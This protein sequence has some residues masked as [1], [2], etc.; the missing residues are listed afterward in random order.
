[1][2]ATRMQR[3]GGPLPGVFNE[4]TLFTADGDAPSDALTDLALELVTTARRVPVDGIGG[5]VDAAF[6]RWPGEH[7]RLLTAAAEVVRPA[8]A[9]D[10]GTADGLSSLALLRSPGTGRVVTFDVEPWDASTWSGWDTV[11]RPSDFGERLVQVVADLGEAGTFAAHAELFATAQLVFVDGPKDGAFEPAFFASLLATPVRAR[12]L[13]IVDDI[14]VLTMVEL[15]RTLPGP[16]LDL[17][18]FGHF[19][20]T[21]L[22]LREP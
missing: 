11:L 16:R 1:M 14:R 22:L 13:V 21:G 20:G 8:V 15:W 18:S 17:T 19:S 12:Q 3:Q 5:R 7:Y 10:I 4:W 2:P 6:D 9:V